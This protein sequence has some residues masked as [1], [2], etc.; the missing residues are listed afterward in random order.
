MI[1]EFHKTLT[2]MR[3]RGQTEPEIAALSEKIE[4]GNRGKVED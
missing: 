1:R 4:V 3:E 2:E